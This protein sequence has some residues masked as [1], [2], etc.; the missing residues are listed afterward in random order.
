M[1]VARHARAPVLLAGDIDRG[2]IFAQLLGTLWLL[3]ADERALVRGLIVNKF[4]GDRT[5]FADGVRLLEERGGVPVLGVVPH[6]PALAVPEEDAVA[7]DSFVPRTSGTAIDIAVIRLPHIANFDDFDPLRAEP[8]VA[9]RYVESPDELGA[10]DAVILPGT[11]STIAD[12]D[13][14]RSTGLAEAV[15]VASRRGAAV[16]GICGGYQMLGRIIR[17]PHDVESR[18]GDVAGLGLLPVET[19]FA[20]GKATFRVRARVLGGPGWLSAAAGQEVDGYEIHMGRSGSG[21]AWLKIERRNGRPAD[22]SD[23][24]VGG[25]G[26]VWGCYLHGLFANGAL[27]RAWLDSLRCGAPEAGGGAGLGESL[28]RLASAVEAALDMERLE[29]IIRESV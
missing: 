24:A 27:R 18:A 26:R 14:L 23:G 29:A 19:T 1:A 2:G 11:K 3:E 6:L 17:D 15:G 16:V 8:A 7:L 22:V 20:R 13:W 12:L 10:P 4:R 28:D 21:C 9:L 5:L 25:D